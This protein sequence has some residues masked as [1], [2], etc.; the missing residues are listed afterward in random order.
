M[1]RSA[2]ARHQ[3]LHNQVKGDTYG[4]IS[5]L[6]YE[7]VLNP[8]GLDLAEESDPHRQFVRDEELRGSHRQFVRDE[9]L[10]GSHRQFV[11]DEELRGSYRPFAREEELSDP[12]RQF[13]RDEE[14]H[15]LTSQGQSADENHKPD[16]PRDLVV[17]YR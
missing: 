11:R 13:V 8:V 5:L 10:R 12:Y 4:G 14:R 16:R 17:Y 15:V 9:E 2:E 7:G 6:P 1:M 3:R